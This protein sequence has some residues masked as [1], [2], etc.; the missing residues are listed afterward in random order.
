MDGVEV[1]I[2]RVSML[3]CVCVCGGWERGIRDNSVPV[4]AEQGGF[5]E[6]FQDDRSAQLRYKEPQAACTCRSLYTCI[7][8][9]YCVHVCRAMVCTLS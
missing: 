1:T 8:C 3:V 5:L 6:T 4:R 9:L 2:K 7:C